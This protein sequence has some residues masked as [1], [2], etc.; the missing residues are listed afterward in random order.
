MGV[1]SKQLRSRNHCWCFCLDLS[2]RRTMC[3]IHGLFGLLRLLA[4][5]VRATV[6]VSNTG[7]IGDNTGH[8]HQNTRCTLGLF[9]KV[10]F[11]LGTQRALT[12]AHVTPHAIA[13]LVSLD[14]GFLKS[15]ARK[16]GCLSASF[17]PGIG[18][19]G[20]PFAEDCPATCSGGRQ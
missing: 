16:S 9:T 14:F 19:Q 15:K 10:Q 11:Q 12:V 2:K 4:E 20:L 5:H 7:S 17:L 3:F 8:T 1:Q 18:K 13:S 6:H